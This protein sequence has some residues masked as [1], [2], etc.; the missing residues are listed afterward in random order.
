MAFHPVSCCF[1]VVVWGSCDKRHRRFL[2]RPHR[3]DDRSAP[4]AGGAG[5]A[6]AVA[7]HRGVVGAAVRPPGA[8]GQA[9]RGDGPV[10]AEHAARW[11]GGIEGG[12][13]AAAD[14]ADDLVAVPEA[15]LRRER[16]GRGRA[17]ERHAALAV[18]LGDGL[19]RASPPERSD[20]AGEVQTTAG[21][22]GG[23]GVACADDQRGGDPEADRPGASV[24]RDRGFDGAAEGGG[25]PDGQQGATDPAERGRGGG[26]NIDSTSPTTYR[27]PKSADHPGEAP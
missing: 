19:L 7:G 3:P 26:R 25:V 23:G 16:R 22:V 6:H 13:P 8:R 5:L 20:G 9:P 2:P 24:E 1:A 15:R 27:R 12:P 21:R 14:A 4:S 10:R 11:R 17:L 18:L